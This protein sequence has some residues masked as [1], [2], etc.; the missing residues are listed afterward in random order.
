LFDCRKR[1]YDV[2]PSNE[3]S[4]S[5]RLILMNFPNEDDD[6][7]RD[8]MMAIHLIIR[9]LLAITQIY[10]LEISEEN[11][12]SDTFLTII[13][14]FPALETLKVSSLELSEEIYS[15]NKDKNRRLTSK[16][17]K[18]RKV[19]LEKLSTIEEVYFLLKHCPRVEYLK[20]GFM[21]NMNIQLFIKDILKKIKVDRNQCLCSLCLHIPTVDGAMT[22]KL[23]E[24]IIGEKLL[25]DFTIKYVLDS[26]YLQWK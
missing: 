22:E 7:D 2:D 9:D 15:F 14:H 12:S 21:H 25:G 26:I 1:W 11:I 16:K 4:N 17:N 20:L 3:I 24:M 19:Y 5:T 8:Y 13:Q 10:H 6:D 23:K 18:I